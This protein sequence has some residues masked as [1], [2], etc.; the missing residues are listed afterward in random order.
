MG[1][2]SLKFFSAGQERFV[3]LLHNPEIRGPFDEDHSNP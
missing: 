1:L 3:F 2:K